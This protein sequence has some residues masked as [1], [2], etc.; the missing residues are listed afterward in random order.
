MLD[1]Y[2][3][4]SGLHYTFTVCSLETNYSFLRARK[5]YE[6]DDTS[7]NECLLCVVTVSSTL[8]LWILYSFQQW[9]EV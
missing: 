7:C 5:K 6:D 8:P 4:K 9:H 3:Q 1:Y 2:F